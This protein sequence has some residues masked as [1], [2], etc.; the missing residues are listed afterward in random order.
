[1]KKWSSAL[2]AKDPEESSLKGAVLVYRARTDPNDCIPV[3]ACAGLADL[4]FDVGATAAAVPDVVTQVNVC[5]L[6]KVLNSFTSDCELVKPTPC[7]ASTKYPRMSPAFHFPG[8]AVKKRIGTKFSLAP[9]AGAQLLSS[10][11]LLA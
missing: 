2:E 10:C 11:P 7:P 6:I 4:V 3:G 5:W 1:V 8:L 9:Q